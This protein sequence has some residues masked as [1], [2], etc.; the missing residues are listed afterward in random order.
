MAGK[1][2][3]CNNTPMIGHRS[4]AVGRSNTEAGNSW[5]WFEGSK[6]FA[7]LGFAMTLQTQPPTPEP[8]EPRVS[9]SSSEKNAMD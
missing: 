1:I 5:Q 9:L 4:S 8:T 6:G 2:E 3:G 7:E